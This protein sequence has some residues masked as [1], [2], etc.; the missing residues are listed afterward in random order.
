MKN[1]NSEVKQL[2]LGIKLEQ[3]GG[4]T[5]LNIGFGDRDTNWIQIPVLPFSI[6]VTSLKLALNLH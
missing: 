5:A 1:G 6:C 3:P 2:D 4:Y